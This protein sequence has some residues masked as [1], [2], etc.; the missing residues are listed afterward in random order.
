MNPTLYYDL[1]VWLGTKEV[2]ED[3]DDWI[4]NILLTAG[5]QYELEGTILYKKKDGK[6]LPV[7]QQKNVTNILK[8]AHKH[9]LAGHVGQQNTLF[10]LQQSV[11]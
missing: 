8:L 10:R 2:R 11:W 7:I 9:S 4:K 3:M 6:V 1:V 5:R